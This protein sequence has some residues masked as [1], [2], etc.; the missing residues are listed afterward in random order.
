MPSSMATGRS[1]S[2]IQTISDRDAEAQARR[3]AS[4][5]TFAYRPCLPEPILRLCPG[6]SDSIVSSD[7]GRDRKP[8][9]SGKQASRGRSGP[10]GSMIL[11]RMTCKESNATPDVV[12]ASIQQ[13]AA[14]SKMPCF[15]AGVSLEELR[16]T[17]DGWA[18]RTS[19]QTSSAANR[20]SPAMNASA[21]VSTAAFR[22]VRSESRRSP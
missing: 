13:L 11:R 22:F 2:R 12:H 19:N 18:Q 8:G 7:S 1:S 17:A 20:R 21:I 9:R 15:Q 16:Q 6:R 10:C 3:L 5:T 4:R 14:I